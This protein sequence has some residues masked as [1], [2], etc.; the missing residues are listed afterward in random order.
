MCTV[1]RQPLVRIGVVDAGD[2]GAPDEQYLDI[3]DVARLSLVE[4]RKAWSGTLQ[5][6]FG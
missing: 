6:L 3:Q 5:E 4:L 1:R 2:T